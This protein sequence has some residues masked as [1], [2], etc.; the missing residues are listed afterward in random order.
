[1]Y[2]L[3]GWVLQ[4]GFS[5]L[6]KETFGTGGQ[7]ATWLHSSKGD[8]SW[9][10]MPRMIHIPVL[11]AWTTSFH[12][13]RLVFSI[14]PA[15]T[16]C[17]FCSDVLIVL[18]RSLHGL[19]PL[20]LA[21]RALSFN[22]CFSWSIYTCIYPCSPTALW[23]SDTGHMFYSPR[24]YQLLSNGESHEGSMCVM[25]MKFPSGNKMA[26]D[27]ERAAKDSW[28]GLKLFELIECLLYLKGY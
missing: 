26:K 8:M 5:C 23:I 25:W 17:K 24:T 21:C 19:F 10:F 16:G 11:S 12:P 4:V 2:N 7:C 20:F 22:S 14:S 9:D 13:L 18:V 27:T 6:F 3:Q 1:M 15:L 28:L